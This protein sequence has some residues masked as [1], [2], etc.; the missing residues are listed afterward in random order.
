MVGGALAVQMFLKTGVI[1]VVGLTVGFV[2]GV[3]VGV[4]SGA[5]NTHIDL[6]LEDGSGRDIKEPSSRTASC[7]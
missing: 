3:V 2:T 4:Q 1:L 5:I 6:C 7:A